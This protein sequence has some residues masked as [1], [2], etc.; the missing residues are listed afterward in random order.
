MTD[1]EGT[2]MPSLA[3][4]L[5]GVDAWDLVHYVLSLRAEK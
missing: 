4:L 5:H 3:G 2:P 1:L